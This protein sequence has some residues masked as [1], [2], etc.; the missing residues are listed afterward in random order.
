M[1][2]ASTPQSQIAPLRLKLLHILQHSLG[3]DNHGNGPQYRN[4]YCANGQDVELCLELVTMGLMRELSFP[5]LTPPNR[6]FTVTQGGT[7][8]V[9]AQRIPFREKGQP[10][11]NY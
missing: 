7:S 8:V 2:P 10:N 4:R 3:V 11:P 6:M 9:S 5:L 1:P